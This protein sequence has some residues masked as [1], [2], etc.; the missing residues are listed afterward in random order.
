MGIVEGFD[1]D[2]PYFITGEAQ[3]L[4]LIRN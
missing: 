4:G 1:A 2:L 3:M